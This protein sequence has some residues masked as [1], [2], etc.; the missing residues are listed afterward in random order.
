M[1]AKL[2]RSQTKKNVMSENLANAIHEFVNQ[3]RLHGKDLHEDGQFLSS[4]E[5]ME[6]LQVI[7]SDKQ[8]FL[9]LLQEPNS[10]LLKYIQEFENAQGRDDKECSSLTTSNCSELELVSLKQTRENTNRKHLNFFRK[11]NSS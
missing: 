3:M 4:R 8:L 10:H 2:M 11:I 5:V 7:S 6:A 1:M 9:K